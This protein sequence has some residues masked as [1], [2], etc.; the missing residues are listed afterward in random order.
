M[1]CAKCNKPLISQTMMF[2]TDHGV[3]HAECSTACTQCGKVHPNDQYYCDPETA[4]KVRQ[5]REAEPTIADLVANGEWAAAG[6]RAAESELIL[7][8]P[9]A[10]RILRLDDNDRVSS[11]G[12]N[13]EFICDA[14]ELKEL[15]R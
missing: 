14:R 11:C 8:K 1:D 6:K 4:E 10:E 7:R 2:R 3:I 12:K 9:L 15:I 5:R 13:A